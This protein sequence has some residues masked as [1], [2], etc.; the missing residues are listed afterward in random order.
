MALDMVGPTNEEALPMML[1]T[2]KKKNSLP[3]GVTSE[4]Y[5]DL[6]RDSE[7]GLGR[8]RTVEYLCGQRADCDLP[9]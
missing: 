6:V 3:R 5:Y 9:S 1:N 2:E 4:I 7:N 8:K